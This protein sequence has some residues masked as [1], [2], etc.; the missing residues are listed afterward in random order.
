MTRED[1]EDML[2]FMDKEGMTITNTLDGFDISNALSTVDEF[3]VVKGRSDELY[4]TEIALAHEYKFLDAILHL[5]YNNNQEDEFDR[6]TAGGETHERWEVREDEV[7]T[8]RDVADSS[9]SAR[10]RV[11]DQQALDEYGLDT[12]PDLSRHSGDILIYEDSSWEDDGGTPTIEE[13]EERLEDPETVA[14]GYEEE[15]SL[16]DRVRDLF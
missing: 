9:Y 5:A 2:D 1:P 3:Q 7:V 12:E 14:V 13:G 15:L 4:A 16:T 6:E 8:T 10:A 11:T